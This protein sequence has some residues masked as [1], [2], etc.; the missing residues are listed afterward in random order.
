MRLD[1]AHDLADRVEREIRTVVP[2]LTHVDVHIEPVD[3][4]ATVA[5]TIDDDAGIRAA[6]SRAATEVTGRD[7]QDVR[8][9]RTERGVVAYVTVLAAGDQ[10]LQ[11]AHV[12]ATRVEERLAELA[13]ELVDVVVHTEPAG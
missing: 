1:A 6:A 8:V 12:L 9:R 2:D 13:P 10:S 3:A 11:D 5:G 4:H 7:A